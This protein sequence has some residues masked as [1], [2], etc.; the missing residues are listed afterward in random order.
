MSKKFKRII[1]VILA[2]AMVACMF[3]GCAT[4]PSN[5]E[6]SSDAVAASTGKVYTI[7]IVQQLEH[8]AL[9]AATQGFKNAVV[10]ALGEDSVKFNFQNGQNDPNT[11]ATIA[12]QFVSDGVDLIMANATTA[13]QAAAAATDEIPVLGTSITT[14][15]V[16]LDIVTLTVL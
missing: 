6:E 16:A 7:G 10:D 15:G 12:N 5:E 1:G 11:C 4:T 8:D 3:A 13:L 2:V 14:Y 9:D